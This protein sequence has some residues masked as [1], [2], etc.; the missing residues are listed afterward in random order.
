MAQQNTVIETGLVWGPVE[1]VRLAWPPACGAEAAFV[2][3]TRAETH[4]DYGPLLE[5]RYEVYRPMAER[6]LADMA[7]ETADAWGAEAIRIAHAEGPVPVGAGSIAIQVATPHR[8]EAFDAC[9]H[10]I[11]RIKHALPVWKTELWE[12]GR[13]FAAGCCAAQAGSAP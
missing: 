1:P 9:R 11:E 2:G 4:E 3:R 10:L 5:L 13:T 6:L 12:R 8:S 7:R